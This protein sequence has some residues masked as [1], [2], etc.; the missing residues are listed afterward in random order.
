M[1]NHV[2]IADALLREI[3]QRLAESAGID[4]DSLEA[5]RIAWVVERR[6]RHLLLPN[7][8]VYVDYLKAAA[9]ELEHLIDALVIQETR[10]FRDHAVF[11]QIKAW[12]QQAALVQKQPLRILSAPCSTGQEPYSVAAVLRLA[13]LSDFTI[14]AFDISHGALAIAQ[15]GVYP[16]GALSHVPADLQRT[17]GHWKDSHWHVIDDL[18]ARVRFEQRNLALSGALGDK[19]G[20][21]LVLCRNLFIYLHASARAVLA[22]S[23]SQALRPDGRL[24]IGTGDRVAEINARFVPIEPAAGFAFTHKVCLKSNHQVRVASVPVPAQIR[25][26]TDTAAPTAVVG[27]PQQADEFYR[28]AVEYSQCGNLRQAERRCRQALYLAP[29]YMPAL[30]LLDALWQKHPSAR[31]RRALQA[32][33]RRIQTAAPDA[34][35]REREMA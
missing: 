1:M 14:D 19:P 2:K 7:P 15:R 4:P 25:R 32:R 8:E 34:I 20:Y 21:D 24:I 30:E 17:C 35:F 26:R 13:G 29:N 3:A 23:L 10:F 18:L 6:R 11:E 33:I 31:L 5:S 22:E 16:A 28:R 12:A 9:E 27:I